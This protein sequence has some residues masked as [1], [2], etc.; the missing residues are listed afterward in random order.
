MSNTIAKIDYHEFWHEF[1]ILYGQNAIWYFTYFIT[2]IM[3]IWVIYLF[4]RH[5]GW[6]TTPLE[7][8]LKKQE[9]NTAK[10]SELIG[11]L[12]EMIR[13]SLET[14]RS[15]L[16]DSQIDIIVEDKI[17]IYKKVLLAEVLELW[18]RNNISDRVN[19]LIKIED[20]F[21]AIIR[22]EDAKFFKLPGVEK[23][24]IPTILKI[25]TFEI[26]NIYEK[27]YDI[28]YENKLV[29]QNELEKDCKICF[30]NM[31]KKIVS[32]CKNLLDNFI[33]NNWKV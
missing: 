17:I 2:F 3:C 4:I 33:T 18:V 11:H 31:E 25:K 29:E 13:L 8:T 24:L 5:K 19:T 6:L 1:V 23:K 22:E 16:T 28:L 26:E 9:E 21:K 20:N 14:Q 7:R 15:N 30:K 32:Q 27:V 12:S 10:N